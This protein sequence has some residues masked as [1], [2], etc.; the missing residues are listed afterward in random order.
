MNLESQYVIN[1]QARLVKKDGTLNLCH[2]QLLWRNPLYTE[3]AVLLKW[4]T[5]LMLIIVTFF[6]SWLLFA[7]LYWLMEEINKDTHESV[8]NETVNC[9]DGLKDFNSALLFSVETM[10]SIGYGSRAPTEHC[11]FVIFL[12]IFQSL[13]GVLI[14]G[15]LTG[16]LRAKFMMPG[17]RK[18]FIKFSN[19]AVVLMRNKKL[20]LVVKVADQSDSKLRSVT[21]TAIMVDTV[22][23][24]EGEIITNNIRN[25]QFGHNEDSHVSPY[26]WPACIAHE[27]N[28]N[29]P[30]YH[31][32]PDMVGE[33]DTDFEL[34][35]WVTG[36][37]SYGGL[38]NARTSYI[39]SEIVWGGSFEFESDFRHHANHITVLRNSVNFDMVESEELPRI[40]AA[41]MDKQAEDGRTNPSI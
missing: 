26:L 9:V 11:P 29:S 13:F 4:V 20:Y 8:H 25:I 35:L 6:G 16:L 30:L 1:D 41:A 36:T 28:S 5:V 31:F 10:M 3:N 14:A 23:T 2:E 33:S 27:I 7:L 32:N 40:S 18:N 15:V 17:M 21:T 38:V 37:T 22:A 34:I 24:E 19:E 39:P 12:T